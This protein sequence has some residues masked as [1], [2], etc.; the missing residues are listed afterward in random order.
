MNKLFNIKI[1]I[2][3]VLIFSMTLG[4]IYAECDCVD[5]FGCIES[6]SVIDKCS[7]IIECIDNSKDNCCESEQCIRSDRQFHPQGPSN[8]FNIFRAQYSSPGISFLFSSADKAVKKVVFHDPVINCLPTNSF[9]YSSKTS[10]LL[11][12]IS[13]LNGVPVRHKLILWI[14]HGNVFTKLC[15]IRKKLNVYHK[16]W[17]IDVSEIIIIAIMKI[18]F[19]KT[20]SVNE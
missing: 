17:I 12:W 8:F 5:S 3:T 7:T 2:A 15:I 10:N 19:F 13:L 18:T 9:L 1:Y 11:I 14:P 4:S 6:Y 16:K 20:R